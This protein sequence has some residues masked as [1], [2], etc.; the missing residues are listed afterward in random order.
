MEFEL[1]KKYY[2]WDKKLNKLG[3][4]T[5]FRLFKDSFTF[6]YLGKGYSCS[7]EYACGKIFERSID[8]PQFAEQNKDIEKLRIDRTRYRDDSFAYPDKLYDTRSFSKLD[9]DVRVI[10]GD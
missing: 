9:P 2:F 5:I 6:E 10:F 7:K 1:N 3:C 4:F 8:V